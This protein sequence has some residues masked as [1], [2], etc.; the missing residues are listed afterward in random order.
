MIAAKLL[1]MRAVARPCG[2]IERDHQTGALPPAP[3]Y[4]ARHLDI[5]RCRLWLSNNGYERQPV[6]IHT[7][8]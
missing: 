4:P 1:E 3:A 7:H 2:G 8:L 6:D 5:L